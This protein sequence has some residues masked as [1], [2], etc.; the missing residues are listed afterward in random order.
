LVATGT[1]FTAAI[2]EADQVIVFVRYGGKN[3]RIGQ[4]YGHPVAHL[5]RVKDGKI[6]RFAPYTAKVL[7]A[8]RG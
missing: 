3:E 4:I 2:G 1:G 8:A 6:R 7:E 5:C